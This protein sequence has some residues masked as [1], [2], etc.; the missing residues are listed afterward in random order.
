MLNEF[1]HDP[2][3]RNRA[4]SRGTLVFPILLLGGCGRAP[5]INI[6]GSFFPTWI[7]C[8]VLGIL[9]TAGIRALGLYLRVEQHLQP[10]ILIYPSLAASFAL[11]LW[12]IC[13][14]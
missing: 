13:F 6:V 7:L 8:I 2:A 1:G 14:S 4:V 5:S 3:K 12:L 11:T 10:P 9:F